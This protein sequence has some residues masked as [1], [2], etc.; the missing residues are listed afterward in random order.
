MDPAKQR[1]IEACG[2]CGQPEDAHKHKTGTDSGDLELFAALG[3][4]CPQFVASDAAVIYAKHLAIADNREPQRQPG[5]IAKR[6]P[7]C[8]RCGHRHRGDCVIAPGPAT[9]PDTAS[10]GAAKA[11]EALG[12][13]RNDDNAE[14]S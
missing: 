6:N 10:Q 9:R 1:A 8:S 3:G 7:L 13:T 14:A 5:R 2:R 12:L 11:R 4:P